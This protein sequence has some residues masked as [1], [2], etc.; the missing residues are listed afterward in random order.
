M[1]LCSFGFPDPVE[2]ALKKG[3][4]KVKSISK[5]LFSHLS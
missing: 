4:L 3:K 2:I 1:D 5:A